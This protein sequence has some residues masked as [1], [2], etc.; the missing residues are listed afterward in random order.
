MEDVALENVLMLSS[1]Q[2]VFNA[3]SPT[4]DYKKKKFIF[5]FCAL[6]GLFPPSFSTHLQYESELD[7]RGD[8]GFLGGGLLFRMG[9]LPVRSCIGRVLDLLCDLGDFLFE[10]GSSDIAMDIGHL[11]G[12]DMVYSN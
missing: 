5:S 7:C 10:S 2:P 12:W 11:D 8:A 4:L 6:C 9:V 3:T 1:S